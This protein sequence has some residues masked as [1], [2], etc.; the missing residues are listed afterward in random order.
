MSSA[1]RP[2]A[3][4]WMFCHP[5]RPWDVSVKLSRRLISRTKRENRSC[6]IDWQRNR[7]A[8]EPPSRNTWVIV[9]VIITVTHIDELGPFLNM[10]ITKCSSL[11]NAYLHNLP[12]T[13]TRQWYVYI[14]EDGDSWDCS[15]NQCKRCMSAQGQQGTRRLY[16]H[17]LG[18]GVVIYWSTLITLRMLFLFY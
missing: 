11:H 6:H 14:A 4:V 9:H 12:W 5:S 1:T 18:R 2:E 7:R 15:G 13:P 10:C 16:S 17:L 3:G 8:N